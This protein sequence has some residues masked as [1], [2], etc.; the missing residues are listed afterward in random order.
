MDKATFISALKEARAE[1]EALLAQID[2]ARMNQPG[3]TGK[4]SVKD[5]I[6]HIAWGELEMVPLL[7]EHSLAKSSE[8][9][10]LSEDERNEEVYQQYRDRPLHDIIDEER[11]AYADMLAAIA[12][13]SDEDLNDPRRFKGMPQDWTPWR[14]VDGNSSKHYRDHAASLRAWLWRTRVN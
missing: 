6:A 11:K 7:R 13:L 8:L 12:G 5:V 10:N 3:A 14:I 1:W 4:W 2:E 9:W